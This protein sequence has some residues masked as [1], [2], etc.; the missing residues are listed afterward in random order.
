MKYVLDHFSNANSLILTKTNENISN[1]IST[2]SD[3][4][5][6]P[7]KKYPGS[8]I[9][10]NE[11]MVKELH[12]KIQKTKLTE[13]SKKIALD[14]L[15]KLKASKGTPDYEWTVTYLNTLLSLPWDSYTVDSDNIFNTKEILDRDH[16]GLEKVKK[17]IIEY[18]S[19]R[20]LIRND[21]TINQK[22]EKDLDNSQNK[23]IITPQD[24]LNSSNNQ[25]ADNKNENISNNK[26]QNI[27]SG[28]ILCF[29]GP[30]GVGKTSLAKSIADALGKKFY[31]ISLGGLKEVSEING[32]RR[33]FVAAMP[34]M[35]IQALRR[36]NSKNPVILLDEIDKVGVNIKGDVSSSLLEVLDPEQNMAFKDHYINTAFDLSQV[37][38]ICTSNYLEN[39]SPPLRDRLEIINI[40]GYSPLEK[41]QICKRYLVPKQ[42]KLNGLNTE[43]V[44]DKGPIN[45]DNKPHGNK[46]KINLEFSEKIINNIILHHT[47]ESGVRQLDRN[48]ASI[49]RYVAKEAV[50]EI[51]KNLNEKKNEMKNY[52]N[53][54]ELEK[55]NLEDLEANKNYSTSNNS[56]SLVLTEDDKIILL[57]N[58][59]ITENMV[60]EILGK[61]REE[62]DLELRLAN[63]GVAIVSLI[64][65]MPYK[66][67]LIFFKIKNKINEI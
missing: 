21:F 60:S 50:E 43:W 10:R 28:S 5:N 19:V 15:E 41:V 48:I 59:E 17:R 63:P 11:G 8:N 9:S 67:K 34:G 18:L 33:T 65:L 35:I 56:S 64:F 62:I 20:K 26:I 66:I 23:E 38:F 27:K 32:H 61:K 7:G 1:A 42:I 49:C 47:Y 36:I 3:E 31:R 29:N 12:E 45:K 22:K 54:R 39:I 14:E 6:E 46:I 30:P 4:K 2:I 52:V 57:K 40:E 25:K 53:N 51:E 44:E 37:F 24:K 13:E 16:F 58:I 55:L